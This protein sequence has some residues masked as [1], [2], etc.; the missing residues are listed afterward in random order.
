MYIYFCVPQYIAC[1]WSTDTN[2]S[3]QTLS[4]TCFL[5][6]L[7]LPLRRSFNQFVNTLS[8]IFFHESSTP[9]PRKV[10]PGANS[11]ESSSVD[12][13]CSSFYH[14]IG[15]KKTGCGSYTHLRRKLQHCAC[16]H[17]YRSGN[18]IECALN[19]TEKRDGCQFSRRPSNAAEMGQGKAFFSHSWY[20][21]RLYFAAG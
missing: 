4:L 8:W 12:I 7:R 20:K 2:Y 19:S 11:A 3:A 5:A 10:L 9:F 16:F 13:L 21:A 18:Q 14:A 1:R 6:T 15:V 17:G